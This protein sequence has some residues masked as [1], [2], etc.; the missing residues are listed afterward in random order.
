MQER[1]FRLRPRSTSVVT[2]HPA[3]AGAWCGEHARAYRSPERRRTMACYYE[4]PSGLQ[5]V[6]EKEVPAGRGAKCPPS[7]TYILLLFCL[8]LKC[9][10]VPRARQN[11]NEEMLVTA[12]A[13]YPTE[14]QY[15]HKGVVLPFVEDAYTPAP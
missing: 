14:V 11:L 9:P 10:R 13:G 5:R 7:N 8:Y 4:A 6:E 3:P 1:V 12:G 2:H 15:T